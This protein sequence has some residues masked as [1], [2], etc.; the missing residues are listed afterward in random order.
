MK[1][2]DGCSD[3]D[4]PA[5]TAICSIG[6][7]DNLALQAV[8]NWIKE[9]ELTE[10]DIRIIRDKIKHSISVILKRPVLL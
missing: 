8:K 5:G 4:T 3:Y 7:D 2:Y 10:E 1:D 6:A 9:K